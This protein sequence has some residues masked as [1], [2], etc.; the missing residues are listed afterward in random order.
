MSNINNE[1]PQV[2]ETKPLVSDKAKAILKIIGISAAFG[3]LA[4]VLNQ[5]RQLGQIVQ[6][7]QDTLE[8]LIDEDQQE[9]PLELTE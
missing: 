5:Q 3:T 1:E 8:V 7:Q 2:V 4:L 6:N 9:E